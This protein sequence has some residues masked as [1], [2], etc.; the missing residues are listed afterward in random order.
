MMT[1]VETSEMGVS[2]LSN[3]VGKPFLVRPSANDDLFQQLKSEFKCT[4][5]WN[6]N[7]SKTEPLDAPNSY[8]DFLIEPSWL[9]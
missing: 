1:Y 6:K 7:H 5:N 8:L 4:I 3:V 9:R 2:I